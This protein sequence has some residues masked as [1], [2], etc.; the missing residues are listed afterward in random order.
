[1]KKFI[2]DAHCDTITKIK[3]TNQQLLKNN[4][5]IDLNRL[6]EYETP[7]QFFAVCLEESSP[8]E[9]LK[10]TL[11]YIDFYYE[12][13]NKY[14]NFIAPVKNYMD[15]L[16][17]KDNNKIS[18]LLSIEGGD[19]IEKDLKNLKL[20]YDKGVRAINLTWNFDNLIAGGIKGQCD[21]LT[22]FG[23]EVIR[24]MEN[25]GIIIDVSHLGQKSFWQVDSLVK[26]PYIASHSN[27]KAVCNNSRNLSDEQL[28]AIAQKN[29]VIGINLYSDFLTDKPYASIEDIITHIDYISSLIGFDYIGL[30]CDFDGIDKMPI[31]IKNISN[32]NLL[33]ENLSNKYGDSKLEK[34]LNLNF[35]RILKNILK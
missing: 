6:S 18:S 4:C 31:Q 9:P 30:G 26:G 33:I 21:T 12:Q 22:D 32:L 27:A 5:H 2:I 10:R 20:L 14:S 3:N 34:L 17:N 35:M 13:L 15:I 23:R 1:M 19:A 24:Y 11:E 7:V 25:L 16:K 28:K 29:G 8:K